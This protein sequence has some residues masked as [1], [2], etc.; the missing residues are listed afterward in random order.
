MAAY[1][2]LDWANKGWFGVAISGDRFACDLFPT[3]WSAW[4]AHR[5]AERILIDIP[6]GLTERDGSRRRCDERAK[7]HLGAQHA[8]VFYAPVRPAV[9]QESITEA[10]AVN[11]EAGFSIQN[12]AWS[13]APRIREVDEF[14]DARP[15]ARDR[16]RE[17]HPEVC[18][19]AWN[20]GS[21]SAPPNTA[22]GRA[23]R[24]DVIAEV[25]PKFREKLDATIE[26]FTSPR[27]A[28]LVTD[29]SHIQDACIAA[30]TARLDEDEL[31]TLPAIPPRDARDLPM[32][33]VYPETAR[34]LTLDDTGA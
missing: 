33:I 30:L 32:E 13:I 27:Y 9:Y 21:L 16:I 22:D 3:I 34:Q 20:G 12:Q 8:S 10:K 26:T 29:R 19:Q 11:E 7:S 25:A 4:H 1:V 17:T 2:G 6:I 23:E 14:L 18:Y 24:Y 15:G 28:P 31:A 5:D